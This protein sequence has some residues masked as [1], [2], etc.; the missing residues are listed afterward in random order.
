MGQSFT[1]GCLW[2]Q[3]RK[4][5]GEKLGKET[6]EMC[7]EGTNPR[8]L[9]STKLSTRNT[10][11]IKGVYYDQ[12]RKKY[13]PTI[14]FKGKPYYLGKYD[15][16]DDAIAMRQRAKEKIHGEFLEWYEEAYPKEYEIIKNEQ[17]KREQNRQEPK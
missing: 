16:K 4:F 11:G 7:V 5:Y 6:A 9:L 3:V 2:D 10:S 12:K 8:N 14:G 15:N 1:C 17:K 13:V